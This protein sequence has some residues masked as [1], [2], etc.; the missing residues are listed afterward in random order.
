MQL[1][2]VV[3][4]PVATVPVLDVVPVHVVK[5]VLE[6]SPGPKSPLAIHTQKHSK[7]A[8]IIS[9]KGRSLTTQGC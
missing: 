6:M 3:Q 8:L 9:G 2:G 5:W 7:D 1:F 4:L